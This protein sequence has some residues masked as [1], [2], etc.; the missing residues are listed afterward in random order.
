MCFQCLAAGTQK[1]LPPHCPVS[2]Y[3]AA[4]A[5]SSI[6][7][8][9]HSCWKCQTCWHSSKRIHRK[10]CHTFFFCP[11]IPT[12]VNP[13]LR[14][15]LLSR[16]NKIHLPKSGA[17]TRGDAR[18]QHA[19]LRGHSRLS[20]HLSVRRSV[21]N[22]N[23]HTIT[24]TSQYIQMHT[25]THSNTST[26]RHTHLAA[27]LKGSQWVA[28]GLSVYPSYKGSWEESVTAGFTLCTKPP[29]NS[30]V[31]ILPLIIIIATS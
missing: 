3:C 30:D 13:S 19:P 27:S 24:H 21:S 31:I 16:N 5:Q 11:S 4:L 8:I 10:Y 9:S 23:S 17:E 6:G 14:P 18:T 29:N 12:C 7:N 25:H 28:S 20:Q 26:H 1:Y 2:E 15:R 22:Y